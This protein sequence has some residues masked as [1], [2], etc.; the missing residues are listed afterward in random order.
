VNFGT[1][2]STS[3]VTISPSGPG[4]AGNSFTLRCSAILTSPIPLP[5]NVPP[6]SFEWFCGPYGNALLPS[7]VDVTPRANFTDYTYTSTLHIDSLNESYAGMYTCRI[8]AGRLENSTTVSVDGMYNIK[9]NFQGHTL[10][11]LYIYSCSC[12]DHSQ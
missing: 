7:G 3:Q 11:V 8:G 9:I 1:A 12:P 4:I 5:S 2:H 6:P 10:I